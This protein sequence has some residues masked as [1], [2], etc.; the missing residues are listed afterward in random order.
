MKA[1][2]IEGKP[3]HLNVLQSF[4]NNIDWCGFNFRTMHIV[5]DTNN[6]LHRI[7]KASPN[8]SNLHQSKHIQHQALQM[9]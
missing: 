1:N 2:Q 9:Y 7:D 8:I 4:E 3:M 6:S 5:D